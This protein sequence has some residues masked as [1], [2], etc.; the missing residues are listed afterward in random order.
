MLTNR[1][2][3]STRMLGIIAGSIVGVGA[4][5][6]LS[7]VFSS[8]GDATEQSS[9]DKLGTSLSS[10][11]SV[12]QATPSVAQPQEGGVDTD[13]AADSDKNSVPSRYHS[14]EHNFLL[15]VPKGFHFTEMSDNGAV[16]LFEGSAGESFQIF[17]IPFDELGPLTPERIKRD[18]PQKGIQN[19]RAGTLDGVKA[20]AFSSREGMEE[21]FEIWFVHAGNLFQITTKADFADTLQKILQTW[22]FTS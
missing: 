7:G 1:D 4:L 14:L 15:D 6:F 2:K 13:R 22:K 10:F 21:V 17:I 11:F 20:L 3:K 12:E 19:P 8:S 16:I 18:L 9:F 5:L